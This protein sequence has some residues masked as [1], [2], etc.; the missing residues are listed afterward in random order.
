M[1]GSQSLPA[2]GANPDTTTVSGFSCGAY[3]ATNL[4]V[5]YSDT[6]KG[7]GLVSG[8]PYMSDKYMP[9]SGLFSPWKEID[10]DASKLSKDTA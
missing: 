4:N 5:V 10:R 3:M 6:F 1:G 9:F 8:G 2:L 7:A